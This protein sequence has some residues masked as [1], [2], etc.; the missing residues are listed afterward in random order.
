MF[1]DCSIKYIWNFK[2]YNNKVGV[3]KHFTNVSHFCRLVVYLMNNV[4]IL[5][6]VELKLFYLY[7]I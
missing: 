3:Y 1:H 7:Y 4:V 6:Y 2:Y 5:P